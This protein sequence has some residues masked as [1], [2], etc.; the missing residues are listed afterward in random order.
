M[1]KVAKWWSS[2][3]AVRQGTAILF[4]AVT[5]TAS[6]TMTASAYIGLPQQVE[7]NTNKLQELDRTTERILNLV[8]FSNCM[9]VAAAKGSPW[10]VCQDDP[11]EY[12]RMN[13]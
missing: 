10:Q 13:K 9:D 12:L 3:S 5:I 4:A 6:V 8:V 7:E 2:L 1:T 11:E